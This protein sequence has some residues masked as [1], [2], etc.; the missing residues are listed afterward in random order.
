M[1]AI[2]NTS[3]I[4]DKKKDK[5]YLEELYH[6]IKKNGIAVYDDRENPLMRRL[7]GLAG[8]CIPK[9]LCCICGLLF[10]FGFTLKRVA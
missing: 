2:K 5:E 6:F 3:R 4:N 9:L 8:S 1:Q 7:L 10:H